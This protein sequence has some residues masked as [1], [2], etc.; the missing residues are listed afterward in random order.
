MFEIKKRN[1]NRML[2]MPLKL[3]FI[4]IFI[5]LFLQSTKRFSAPRVFLYGGRKKNTT[6]NERLAK[7]YKFPFLALLVHH[8]TLKFFFPFFPLFCARSAQR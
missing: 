4:F 8:F 3:Y 7:K 2:A 1:E 6:E 5:S